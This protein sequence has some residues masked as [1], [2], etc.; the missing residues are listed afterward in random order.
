[1]TTLQLPVTDFAATSYFAALDILHILFPALALLHNDFLTWRTVAFVTLE[2]AG[3]ATVK[4]F[5]TSS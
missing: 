2:I 5:I 4:Y 1:M 3:M